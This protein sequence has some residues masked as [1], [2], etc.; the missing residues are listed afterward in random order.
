MGPGRP[1]AGERR[2]R[3]RRSPRRSRPPAPSGAKGDARRAGSRQAPAA[4]AS[5]A[6][7]TPSVV[8]G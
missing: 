1:V 5:R 3:G 8:W 6:S 4:H 2:R 7:G